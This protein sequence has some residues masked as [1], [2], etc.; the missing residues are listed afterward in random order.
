MHLFAD[1]G[2]ARGL[3]WALRRNALPAVPTCCDDF[4]RT[5]DQVQDGLVT[6]LQIVVFTDSEK[7]LAVGA[8]PTVGHH[9]PP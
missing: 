5:L 3:D 7:S 9:G 2:N 1:G 6:D 4:V 8:G